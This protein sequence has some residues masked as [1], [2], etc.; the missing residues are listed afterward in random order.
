MMAFIGI[1][2]IFAIK[3]VYLCKQNVVFDLQYHGFLKQTAFTVSCNLLGPSIHGL[4]TWKYI[5]EA[6]LSKPSYVED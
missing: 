4:V 1:W 3:N 6:E 2:H 5:V